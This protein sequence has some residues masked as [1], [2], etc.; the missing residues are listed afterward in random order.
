MVQIRPKAAQTTGPS[1]SQCGADCL[2]GLNIWF[3]YAKEE[4]A[5][6][7]LDALRQLTG[8]PESD[9]ILMGADMVVLL[10][11]A[12]RPSAG[13][14]AKDSGSVAFDLQSCEALGG[15]G[16]DEQMAHKLGIGMELLQIHQYAEDDPKEVDQAL[17][18]IWY[19]PLRVTP[20]RA[21]AY[22]NS[23]HGDATA[24][25]EVRLAKHGFVN[26]TLDKP[27]HQ[28]PQARGWPLYDSSKASLV[29]SWTPTNGARPF[30]V[31][32][33]NLPSKYCEGKNEMVQRAM[34]D[35]EAILDVSRDRVIIIGDMNTRFLPDAWEACN[36]I[37]CLQP[38]DFQKQLEL[39]K[40]AWETIPNRTAA[41]D[42]IEPC[43]ETKPG[44]GYSSEGECRR[45]LGELTSCRQACISRLGCDLDLLGVAAQSWAA[46]DPKR[47]AGGFDILSQYF[48]YPR[49]YVVKATAAGGEVQH[50]RL[51][52]YKR[53]RDSDVDA[54]KATAPFH[55]FCLD[56]PCR[57]EISSSIKGDAACPESAG[58]CFRQVVDTKAD[59]IPSD[60][61][62]AEHRGK[63]LVKPQMG[64]LDAV[65]MSK[66]LE[67]CVSVLMYEDKPSISFGDHA[68]FVAAVALDLA[69]CP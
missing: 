39:S 65:G 23:F 15:V 34:M 25:Q 33:A 8:G 20:G 52:T 28:C 1:K 47:G 49:D 11:L 12:H 35:I 14:M 54:C 29:T 40:Q 48:A 43:A 31:W 5:C 9:A 67:P 68:P 3:G 56:S 55:G 41:A 19:N 2:E 42:D 30:A 59:M 60:D 26:V 32:G 10:Q 24:C 53:L 36:D 69:G 6:F 50:R 7:H 51:P 46:L 66:S 38:T 62:M 44:V 18:S 63:R 17:L 21:L 13:D 27:V 22:K 16:L 58:E 64:W 37:S 57:W 45:A 61:P 4:L